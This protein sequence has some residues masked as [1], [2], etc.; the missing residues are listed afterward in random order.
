MQ[1]SYDNIPDNGDD[2]EQHCLACYRCKYK[3]QNFTEIPATQGGD[4]GIEA[5][6]S[7]GVVCQCYCPEREYSDED[8]YIHLRD[9]MTQDIS[10]L[11]ENAIRYEKMGIP[12]VREWHFMIPYY[13]DSRII[14][15]AETKRKEVLKLVATDPIK[16]KHISTDF[17]IYIVN[18]ENLKPWCIEAIRTN[19]LNKGLDFSNENIGSFD[20]RECPSEK[21]SNIRRKVRA[22]RPVTS[23]EDLEEMVHHFA[24]AYLEGLELVEKIR[25]EYPDLYVELYSLQQSYTGIVKSKSIMLGDSSMNSKHFREILDDFGKKLE[26]QIDTITPRTITM[27]QNDLVSGW[28]ADCSLSFA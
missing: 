24:K 14:E 20:W 8:L 11:I 17:R 7:T 2:W 12:Q 3:E 10:K 19:L 28:L 16:C 23:D 5:F 25:V 15:H 21:I 27:L 22:V 4:A 18:F 6:T 1:M 9:K 13:R 26:E